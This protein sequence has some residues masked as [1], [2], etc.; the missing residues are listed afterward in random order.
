[1]THPTILALAR[2]LARQAA[3]A[4]YIRPPEVGGNA[5]DNG[6]NDNLKAE[7]NDPR[8]DLRQVQQRPPIR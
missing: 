1:M 4:Q 8:R 6:A 2:L 5:N 3:T 7:H